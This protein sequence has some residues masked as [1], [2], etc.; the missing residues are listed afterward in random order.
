MNTKFAVILIVFGLLTTTTVFGNGL[1]LNSIGT[2]ALGMGG[3]HI[4]LANDYSAIY[5]NPA[6]I[7]QLTHPQVSIFV[8][9]VIP[10]ATYQFTFPAQ[11]GG[12]AIDATAKTNHYIS[13]NLAGYLPLLTGKKLTVGLGAYVPAGLGA[14]WDGAELAAFS[15][16]SMT[17]FEWMSKI[18][19]FN[20]SPGFAYKLNEKFSVGAAV[21]V[22]YGM[23]DMK[24]PMDTYSMLT[25]QPGQDGLMDAQYDESGSGLG[26]GVTLGALFKPMD[27]LS[28]GFTLRTKTTVKFEGTAK[29][30]AFKV[31]NAEETDYERD[32]AWPVWIGGGIALKPTQKLA[33]TADAQYSKW[34]DTEEK[35]ITEYLNPIW[36]GA[37]T[38][39]DRTMTLDW[40]D[41]TQ[42][43]LGLQYQ[44]NEAATLRAG[45]Y[46]DPAPAPDE[47]LNIIFPSITYNA[48]TLGTSYCFGKVAVDLAGEYLMGSDREIDFNPA[49]EA[50]PGTH[51]MNILGI[52]LGVTYSFK[53]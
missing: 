7:T 15:G 10:M 41:A 27:L 11:Y 35:I 12:A 33:I 49:E 45:Y 9:D 52:S 2:N 22:Y 44:L 53:N 1:S 36:A 26:Y 18:A 8:T 31:Y 29:N 14:E 21:N 23:M 16:P 19:V 50:M 42:I 30:S 48:I 34:S 25:Q 20:I 38:E 6:G 17:A 47:T 5:W 37:L 51:H 3:A 46:H 4:A 43:R 32:L 24:R 39:E 40:V 28:V 13:P